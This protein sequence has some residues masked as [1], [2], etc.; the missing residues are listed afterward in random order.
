MALSHKDEI[1]CKITVAPFLFFMHH[2]KQKLIQPPTDNKK[3]HHA[4]G[5]H[6]SLL[7]AQG[8]LPNMGQDPPGHVGIA[9]PVDLYPHAAPGLQEAAVIRFYD[10][11]LQKV[12][13]N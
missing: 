12:R 13:I 1:I 5:T 4:R 6:A 10:I 2:N 11:V 7:L 8:V 3:V 9:I